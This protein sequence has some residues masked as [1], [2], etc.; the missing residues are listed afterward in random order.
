MQM[1]CLVE[2]MLRLLVRPASLVTLCL[3]RLTPRLFVRS[4]RPEGCEARTMTLAEDFAR[5]GLL[6]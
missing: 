5:L 4:R 2:P 6:G 3:V 1:Q